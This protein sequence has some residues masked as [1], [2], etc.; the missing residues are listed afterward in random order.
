MTQNE[1][2]AHRAKVAEAQKTL[3]DALYTADVVSKDQDKKIKEHEET[4]E[5]MQKAMDESKKAIEKEKKA[6]EKEKE[7]TDAQARDIE[8][9][10]AK[11]A[12]LEDN[13]A[14]EKA[15]FEQRVADA[16][17]KFTE[18][19]WYRVW[20]YNPDAN[21]EFLGSEKEKL[22]ALWEARWEEEEMDN[23][24]LST[25]ITKEDYT[26]DVSSKAS[27]QF[28]PQGKLTLD[29]EAEAMLGDSEVN[30]NPIIPSEEQIEAARLETV[31]I[32][33]EIL[34]APTSE[35]QDPPA[36]VETVSEAQ[37]PPPEA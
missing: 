16:E 22:F 11:V 13:L 34:T 18:L 7:K 20:T 30:P 10:Q 17:D 27:S 19:A 1:L 2:G 31:Q 26:Q 23:V 36:P 8:L 12:M 24:S 21:Y 35:T 14:T 37:D 32:V 9:L 4:I 15:T 29:A 28:V 25:H 6:T 33:R 5:N 3:K